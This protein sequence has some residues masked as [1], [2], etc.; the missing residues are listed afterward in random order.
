MESVWNVQKWPVFSQPFT[1]YYDLVFVVVVAE[2]TT[3]ASDVKVTQYGVLC[4]D[5]LCKVSLLIMTCVLVC[6]LVV[7]A[8]DMNSLLTR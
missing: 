6:C 8:C 5:V 7:S 1:N 4:S 3:I 2:A